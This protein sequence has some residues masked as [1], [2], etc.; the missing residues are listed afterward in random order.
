MIRIA[1][2]GK[3]ERGFVR[4]SRTGD[5]QVRSEYDVPYYEFPERLVE[6]ARVMRE[7]KAVNL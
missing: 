6:L 7:R 5:M 4:I 2:R 1:T 3:R